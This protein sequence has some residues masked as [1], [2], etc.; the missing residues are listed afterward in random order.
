MFSLLLLKVTY[1]VPALSF[2]V[3]AYMSLSCV[4]NG[5]LSRSTISSLPLRTMAATLSRT[6]EE[7]EEERERDRERSRGE[8]SAMRARG[9]GDDR[10]ERHWCTWED[11]V[12]IKWQSDH[13]DEEGKKKIEGGGGENYPYATI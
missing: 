2:L 13:R 3:L 5:S 11:W 7:E 9:K 4:R 8:V 10:N 12:V 6:R 1:T